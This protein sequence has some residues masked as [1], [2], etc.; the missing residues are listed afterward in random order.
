[1]QAAGGA[2]QEIVKGNAETRAWKAKIAGETRFVKF[3][4]AA[5]Y[6]SRMRAEVALSGGRLHPAIVPL[7]EIIPCADGTLLIYP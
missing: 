7:L 2:V 4:P 1:M 5:L 3:Y 6:E